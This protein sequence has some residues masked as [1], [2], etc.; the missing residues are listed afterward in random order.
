MSGLPNPEPMEWDNEP[1]NWEETGDGLVVDVA[2]DTDYWRHTRHDFVQ[3]NAH[4]YGRTAD[5]DFVAA[6][7]VA[8]DYATQ[9]DQ[10]GLFVGADDTRWLKCGVEYVD[11]RRHASVVVTRESSD[12]SVVPLSDVDRPSAADPVRVRVRRIGPDVEVDY[13]VGDDGFERIRQ[14]RLTDADELRVGLMGAAPQGDGFRAR[15]SGLEIDD[16]GDP[17]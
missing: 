13:A 5:G 7:T 14:A 15:F 1:P 12:W 11:G 8:G 9:Y 4:V 10:A 2:G 16:D 3:S 6:V 17:E